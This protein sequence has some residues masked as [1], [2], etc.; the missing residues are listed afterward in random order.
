MHAFDVIRIFFGVGGPGCG[1]VFGYWANKTHIGSFLDAFAARGQ[2]P[3][4]DAQDSV[5]FFL[6]R[7]ALVHAPF[8]SSCSIHN[9]MNM[10][11]SDVRLD[12]S[13]VENVHDCANMKA[14]NTTHDTM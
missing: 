2:G 7:L 10:V 3:L 13:K 5:C 14:V 8:T 12:G 9:T 4:Q 11:T 1:C 6:N